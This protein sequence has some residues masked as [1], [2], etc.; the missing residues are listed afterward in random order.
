MKTRREIG[1]GMT[2]LVTNWCKM[3]TSV[4]RRSGARAVARGARAPFGGA[5]ARGSRPGDQHDPLRHALD[6]RDLD[7]ARECGLRAREDRLRLAATEHIF[8]FKVTT[9]EK[10]LYIQA[11]RV[12]NRPEEQQYAMEVQHVEPPS[13]G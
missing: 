2:T 12:G 7:P 8:S 1:R 3:C 9:I 11:I 6:A 10:G 4:F 13:Q 5:S